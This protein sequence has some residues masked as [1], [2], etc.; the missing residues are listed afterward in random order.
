MLLEGQ[1]RF[2]PGEGFFRIQSRPAR[3]LGVL[4]L[5]TLGREGER[6]ALDLMSGCGIRALRYGLEAGASAVW[7]NDADPDRMPQLRANLCGL[8][9][10]GVTLHQSSDQA[11]KLLA[12]TLL[13]GERFE[14]VDLDAF[15]C[16]AALVPP[17][18]QVLSVG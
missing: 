6:R 2:S 11:H 18:L 14:L 9:G 3:D 15:G 5:R 12:E 7:A 8:T 1:A 16:P 13:R 4:L 10:S 17:A